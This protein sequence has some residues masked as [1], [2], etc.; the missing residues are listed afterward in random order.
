MRRVAGGT[1]EAPRFPLGHA[2]W[3]LSRRVP[4]L[5]ALQF[6]FVLRCD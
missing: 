6:A 5:F 1:A 4:R 2:R 3:W